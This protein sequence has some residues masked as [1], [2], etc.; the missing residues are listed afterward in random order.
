MTNITKKV[1]ALFFRAALSVAVAVF[2]S[3]IIY[4]G[5]T[6]K[7][8]A[9]TNATMNFQSR[10]LTAAGAVVPDGNYN[11]EFKLYTASS[12]SGS[13]Q[14][15]C[16]GDAACVWTETRTNS[17]RVRVVNGYMTVNL[18]SVTAFGNINWD[19][20]LWMT[21][22][23]GGT[24]VSP[25]WDGEMAP[26]LKLTGVPYAFRAG[27][28]ANTNGANTS[29]LGWNLQ[30][31]SNA[32]YLPNEGGTICIQNS[33]NCGFLTSG[34]AA[35]SFVQLQGSTP[36]SVQTGNLNI[37]GTAIAG[38]ALQSPSV[39]T[40]V[41]DRSSSGTLAIGTTNA[42][43]I[44]LNQNTT[45]ASGKT[46]TVQGDALFQAATNS[47]TALRVQNQD[48][49]QTILS[50][51]TLNNRVGIN[52]A[53]PGYALDT[54]GDINSSTALKVGG[55]TV[56]TATGC[57]AASGS[58]SYIQ[59]QSSGTQT[60]NFKI[61]GS[62]TNVNTATI[63]AVT[64][65]NNDLLQ[66]QSATGTPIAGIRPSGAI[67][68]AAV[69]DPATDI[70]ANARLFVQP[71]SNSSTAII[72]RAASGGAPTGDILQLQNATGSANLFTVG[73]AGAT[74]V[75]NTSASALLVQNASSSAV[76]TVNTSTS[77][78]AI[79]AITPSYTLDVAGD[80]NSSTAIRV[81]GNIVCTSSGCNV[82]AS[83]AIANQTTVQSANF[84]V[85]AATSGSVAGILQANSAGT[86]NILNLLNGSGTLVGS[87]S[88]SGAV[89]FKP[90]T[91]ATTAFQI[92]ASGS[93]TP[94][95]NVDTSNAYVGVGT[96]TPTRPLDVSINTSSTN[97]LPLIVQQ[98]GSGDSG[99]EIKNTSNNYYM[100]IDSTDNKFKISSNAAGGTSAL[101][102]TLIGAG[103]DS[104]DS[105][106]INGT[107]FT[108]SVTGTTSTLN[109]YVRTPIGASGNNLG[110]MA[111][112][113]DN[114][115]DAPGTLLGSTTST[116]LTG[117]AWNSFALS[118]P[119]PITSG[120]KYWLAY[121]TNGTAANQNNMAYESGP[122]YLSRYMLKT[123]G[124]WSG[125]Y[126]GT[127]S[128]YRF[129]VFADVDITP[130][131][132]NFSSSL[133]QMSAS[134]QAL[135]KNNSNSS[136]AFQI[137]N[138]AASNLFSVDSSAGRVQVG[139]STADSTATL[140]VVDSYNS[141]DPAGV[142]GAMYYNSINQR[143][144]CY[145]NGT[146]QNCI[147]SWSSA[148]TTST[149]VNTCTTACGAVASAAT[150]WPSSY[151]VAG[152]SFHIY[153]SGV[154]ST[155]GTPTIS[156]GVYLG[157]SPTKASNTL[158]G[159]ASNA[160]TTATVTNLGWEMDAYIICNSTTSVLIHGTANFLSNTAGASVTSKIYTTAA[161]T[162]TN[163]TMNIY[164]FPAWGTSSASN[165][166]TANQFIIR[167]L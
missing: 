37:S 42:T 108:A 69:N 23:V 63:M 99:I 136:T 75:T 142:P 11:V 130:G 2:A 119:V 40:N 29:T 156:M 118:S 115:S 81:G 133:F 139:S 113:A 67:Y 112:Y 25:V 127:V 59:N 3:C 51:N 121:N 114:G 48:A 131:S 12:S 98:A 125:A 13:G 149:T 164:L 150:M 145:E 87:V 64:S 38:T 77:R 30:T 49:S 22:N 91:N 78:V 110:Q 47:A 62:G 95:L 117:N 143:F 116:V 58:A 28:L 18:G 86:G 140:F 155:T 132:D 70:P 93:S 153:A 160:A 104:G 46:L 163:S 124:D 120:Q 100:G 79:G 148:S 66:F 73:A 74:T 107:Q 57:T 96:A 17:N 60:A 8:V 61:Q 34:G 101:G 53:T 26:R 41:L 146:W 158:I 128:N 9:A 88:S 76:L 15:S 154:Y 1:S 161:T 111:I 147:G 162:I 10:L 65:Q 6:N 151:C 72:A 39:L 24:A 134:G 43:A 105:N 32:I 4:S 135:F 16:S 19:Q 137:Q 44:N 85:Q 84:Y 138:A 36:G 33:V 157:T 90:S 126:T 94:I 122:S 102:T 97:T 31:A 80:I 5:T 21:M 82:S 7:A 55:T 129:S 159:T 144:R 166:I 106:F 71:V 123:F 20:E 103:V 141:G 45:V 92:Q 14:G 165:T 152:R 54:V 83:S 109:A 167:A 52:T 50:V 56:C 35:G 27:S 68:S 89:L